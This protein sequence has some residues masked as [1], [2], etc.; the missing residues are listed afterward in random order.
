[1]K[2][3]IGYLVMLGAAIF[4]VVLFIATVCIIYVV[5]YILLQITTLIIGRLEKRFKK[6]KQAEDM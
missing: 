5:A 2:P 1:M 3:I 4:I 6:R